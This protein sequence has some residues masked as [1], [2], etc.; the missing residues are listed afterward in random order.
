MTLSGIDTDK[1]SEI[2]F[3]KYLDISKESMMDKLKNEENPYSRFRH[4]LGR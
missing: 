4:L 2:S 3:E 1:Y